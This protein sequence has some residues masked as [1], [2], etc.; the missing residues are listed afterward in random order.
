MST[1]NEKP[2][3][4]SSKITVDVEHFKCGTAGTG[5]LLA[6]STF[7]G[8][9][10]LLMPWWS[11][12]GR[13]TEDFWG[14]GKDVEADI[15]LLTACAGGGAGEPAEDGTCAALG[16]IITLLIAGVGSSGTGTI[17]CAAMVLKCHW[18]FG[19]LTASVI[20][21]AS[22]VV[23]ILAVFM[24]YNIQSGGLEGAGYYLA[25]FS[26]F[27]NVA[28]ATMAVW[29]AN[30]ATP[31]KEQ[32]RFVPPP[33]P[34]PRLTR[35]RA[36]LDAARDLAE[37]MER[38]QFQRQQILEGTFI[39][40]L[41]DEEEKPPKVILQRVIDWGTGEE[42]DK[43]IPISLLEAAFD[44][45]DE[46]CTGSITQQELAASLTDCGLTPSP[47]AM[48][49]IMFEIDR[50]NNGE[51]DIHEFVS[52]F[53]MT[54]ELH[55]FEAQQQNRASVF[56]GA[57]S[58]CFC[59]NLVGWAAVGMI[60]TPAG[61]SSEDTMQQLFKMLSG[62]MVILFLFNVAIP[63]AKLTLGPSFEAWLEVITFNVSEFRARKR[64]KAE[65]KAREQKEAEELEKRASEFEASPP[66]SPALSPTSSLALR[67][68]GDGSSVWSGA[69]SP[70]RALLP[71]ESP[72]AL[73]PPGSPL[74]PGSR[75]LGGSLWSGD[76]NEEVEDDQPGVYLVLHEGTA[77]RSGISISSQKLRILKRGMQVRIVEVFEYKQQGRLRG[78]LEPKDGKPQGW[79]SLKDTV[80]E[81]RW[82]KWSGPLQRA[83]WNKSLTR[84]RSCDLD[85]PKSRGSRSPSS[86]GS[87][88]SRRSKLAKPEET[89]G[90]AP[91]DPSNYDEGWS[92]AE[93]WQGECTFI[94][95]SQVRDVR[96]Y[97]G[98][99]EGFQE[100][101]DIQGGFAPGSRGEWR[102]GLAYKDLTL[103][104]KL[105]R[106]LLKK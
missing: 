63:M 43:P 91:Y 16:G 10:A 59:L 9:F 100:H 99:T 11:W 14:I 106:E 50:D 105:P 101:R 2:P 29:G 34:D 61:S 82:A 13:P 68:A 94:G 56:A 54:E 48:E 84:A 86:R 85:S 30:K 64:R 79:V 25:T 55:M 92:R 62:G 65:Q 32:Q 33:R 22:G 8:L 7:A 51:I 96:L 1:E 57:C 45:I 95:T 3:E 46:D 97:P 35:T 76:S 60:R 47:E 80:D 31:S 40:T 87:R 19:L 12:T 27:F 83:A 88:T 23:E 71:P 24:A 102:A 75:R 72:K 78:R 74:S 98:K 104:S 69:E 17:V 44:E 42:A 18:I 4:A 20:A 77:V 67:A 70:P 103:N 66:G 6:A 39:E 90:A 38:R 41:E 37:A 28:A 89:S 58:C 26:V 36:A 73:L 93:T 15:A 49:R 21:A 52:F 81:Y 53:K 5:A